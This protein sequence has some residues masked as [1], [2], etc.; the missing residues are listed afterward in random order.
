MANN[1]GSGIAS[2]FL[3]NPTAA[4][5]LMWVLLLGGFV[6]IFTMRQEVFPS[7]VLDTIEIR[8]EYRGSTASEVE[9]QV[10]QRK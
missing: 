1:S 10:V 6:A 5:L 9:A 7:A 2:W 8:T 4:N 3:H